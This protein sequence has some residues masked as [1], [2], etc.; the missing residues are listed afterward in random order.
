MKNNEEIWLN[1]L[2]ITDR[3]NRSVKEGGWDREDE[4]GVYDLKDRIIIRILSDTPACLTTEL[5]YV[6]YLHYC[7]RSKDKAG[8]L[9]R[10]DNSRH[11]FEYYL[12]QTEPCPDDYEVPG[13]ATVEVRITCLEQSFCFHM[14]EE[15]MKNCGIAVDKLPRK[16]W[17]SSRDFHHSQFIDL[18]KQ[19]DQLLKEMD[20]N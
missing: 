3:L 4:R 16:A 19:I 6:P 15:T 11:P 17:I 10:A 7:E 14:P 2:A 20:G 9:M 8:A 1:I 18:Q 5:Y 13:K 12:G